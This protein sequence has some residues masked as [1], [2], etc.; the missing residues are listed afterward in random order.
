MDGG[1]SDEFGYAVAINEDFL[2]KFSLDDDLGTNSG[3]VYG[4]DLGAF[5]SSCNASGTCN[6]IEGWSG[7][8]CSVSTCGDG[9]PVGEECDDREYPE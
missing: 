3:A 4:Y 9:F 8:D 5:G 7:N 6:C 2:C 1:S